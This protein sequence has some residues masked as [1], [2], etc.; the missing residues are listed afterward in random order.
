MKD[1][2]DA[3]NYVDDSSYF[4]QSDW[5]LTHWCVCHLADNNLLKDL[6]PTYVILTIST[7]NHQNAENDKQRVLLVG[8]EKATAALSDYTPGLVLKYTVRY[9]QRNFIFVNPFKLFLDL[10]LFRVTQSYLC[11]LRIQ[12]KEHWNQDASYKFFILRSLVF[13]LPSKIFQYFFVWFG[14]R[15]Q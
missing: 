3:I 1:K 7:L 4:F 14:E 9:V 2:K 11:R 15:K 12:H 13:F 5:R 10:H 6:S 8:G